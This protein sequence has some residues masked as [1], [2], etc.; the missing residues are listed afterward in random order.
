[1]ADAGTVTDVYALNPYPEAGGN[2]GDRQIWKAS[3]NGTATGSMAI[4]PDSFIAKIREL[5]GT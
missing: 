2:G 4:D 3:L 1:M 5:L